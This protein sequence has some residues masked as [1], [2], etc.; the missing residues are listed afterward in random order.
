MVSQE[1]NHK[2]LISLGF[3]GTYRGIFPYH[4]VWFRSRRELHLIHVAG[5]LNQND[6][7]VSGVRDVDPARQRPAP[8]PQWPG[9]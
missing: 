7:S 5:L 1:D 8:G 6:G 9:Q 2:A 4:S 3:V